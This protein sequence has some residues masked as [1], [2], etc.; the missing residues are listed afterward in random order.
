MSEFTI[1]L[2]AGSIAIVVL[3]QL[4]LLLRKSAFETPADLNTRLGLLEQN[5][6]SLVQASARSEAGSE[7]V[8]QQLRTF[9]E[10][11][12]QAFEASRRTLDDKL[13]K[14]VEESRNA[15]SELADVLRAFEGR[16]EQRLNILESA[17][18]TRLADI[19]KTITENLKATREVLDTKLAQTQE[20]ARAGRVELMTAFGALESKL[21]TRIG[22]FD[23][24]M[25]ARFEALQQALLERMNEAANAQLS[26]FGQAQADAA[27]ARK[28]M[29]ETLTQFRNELNAT[30]KN[31]S[32]ETQSSREALAHSTATFEKQIQE[33]FD[34]LAAATK[35]TLDSLKADIAAQ[36][37]VMSTALKD[38][39]EANGSQIHKQFSTLQDAVA[40]QLQTMAQG[41]QQNS[42]QL[43][44]ALNERLAAIQADNTI[45][46]EEMR[47]TVDEKLHA[48]LEQRLGDSF[49]LV[50]ERLEQ[51]H[52]GLGEMKNLAGSV[53]DLKRVM[54]NVRARGTWG[55]VQLGAIIESLLTAEQYSKNVKT[56]PGNNELVEYAI[57][58]PGKGNDETV[59][60]PIDSKYPVEHYQRLTDAHESMDKD[61]VQKAAG[62]FEH[63]LR[64]E[65]KKIAEK[66]V[67]PP[68]TT[69]FAILFLP[70]EGLFAE[71]CRVPGMVEAL[72]NDFR[73]VVAGPTTLAA[74][75]NSLRLG[76]R[77][78]AI[79][80][81][82][83]EVWNIL[84]TVKTEFKKFGETVDA[85]Q[86]T[87]DAA[88]NKF[89]DIGRRTRA[90][91]R[92][93]RDV[94]ELPL[95]TATAVGDAELLAMDDELAE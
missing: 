92:K 32:A 11:S 69:D 41:S 45:K 67:S 5:L 80:K 13:D 26:Q 57:K 82:S 51:V 34:A 84:S 94:E 29:V 49:K 52:A 15:R 25:T 7:R 86:K 46:L 28:E 50:S 24:S 89:K 2:L 88:A 16:L 74:M 4:V 14:T 39:L 64:Q 47:R 79:E 53:G 54:T 40:Q 9:T 17:V 20:D 75:L 73:V 95:D 43:R 19:Q 78:L 42:E 63:S 68:H 55:E 30:L 27:Q 38:Q 90:I 83:S 44:T 6:Q 56:V 85:T 12:A 61:Q 66:Y 31:L 59:W 37:G 3:L 33:R 23:T 22:A 81:R 87:I 1:F 48:T 10:T 36:L 65:A 76:F 35:A 8:E 18:D 60:L 71:V 72:Q 93:L 62:A 21:E 91:E 58:M 77:T 70:T